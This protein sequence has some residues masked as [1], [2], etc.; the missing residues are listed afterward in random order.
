MIP[1]SS[2]VV[3]Q[4]QIVPSSPSYFTTISSAYSRDVVAKMGAAYVAKGKR[5]ASHETSNLSSL[6]IFMAKHIRFT[7]SDDKKDEAED[8]PVEDLAE[9]TEVTGSPLHLNASS[10]SEEF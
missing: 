2:I 9:E 10:Q 3:P 7:Y 5:I 4:P 1:S 8:D 6:P